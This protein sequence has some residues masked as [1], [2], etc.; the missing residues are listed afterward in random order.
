MMTTGLQPTPSYGAD[1]MSRIKKAR[2]QL[3]ITQQK[4]SD[5]L[6]IPKRTIENWEAGSRKPPQWAERLILEKM[7]KMKEEKIM[8]VTFVPSYDKKKK[9]VWTDAFPTVDDILSL[10][11]LGG[12]DGDYVD[13]TF[14]IEKYGEEVEVSCPTVPFPKDW[15][16]DEYGKENYDYW[17]DEYQLQFAERVIE[18]LQDAAEGM[19]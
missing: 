7:K 19:S 17:T 13:G 6:G 4:L 12:V 16:V 1:N 9:I 15:T 10:Q 2:A 3:G 5:L 11:I 14:T 8:K 18:Q